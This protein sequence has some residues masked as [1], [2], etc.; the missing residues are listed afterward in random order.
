MILCHITA[1]A[2]NRVIGRNN[3]LPWHI[4]EDFQF[5]KDK[6][7]NHIL[8]M[9]R[10]TYESLGGKPLPKRLHIVITRNA[11]YKVDHPMVIVVRSLAEA[12]EDARKRIQSPNEE[13]FI[14]GGG[15]IYTQ[16]LDQ[17]QK[18]YLTLIDQAYEGDAYYPE[19]SGHGF[20]LTEKVPRDGFSFCVF[21]KRS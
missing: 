11:D 3:Q 5:F 6:T 8:I 16:S 12:I 9:G 20:V 2:S 14:A 13:V 15:E 10:L 19:W 7:K 18:L 4:P 21:E 17:V 1:L